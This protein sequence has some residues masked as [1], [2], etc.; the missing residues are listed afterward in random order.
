MTLCRR[1]RSAAG[2]TA[3][4]VG[5]LRQRFEPGCG[6]HQQ[7]D[8]RDSASV[9]RTQTSR[10]LP[11][12]EKQTV[13]AREWPG[14]TGLARMCAAMVH[15]CEQRRRSRSATFTRRPRSRQKWRNSGQTSSLWLA[16]SSRSLLGFGRGRSRVLIQLSLRLKCRWYRHLYCRARQQRGVCRTSNCGQE[17]SFAVKQGEPQTARRT[18]PRVKAVEQTSVACFRCSNH[19]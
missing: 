12:G 13:I 4:R 3:A 11:P 14:A 1:R 7:G 10:P 18:G 5:V 8:D 19:R 9:C 17:V 15:G 6:H 16:R 2:G